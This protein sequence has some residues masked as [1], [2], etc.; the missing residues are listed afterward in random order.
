MSRVEPRP[1]Q[2]GAVEL[3]AEQRFKLAALIAKLGLEGTRKRLGCSHVTLDQLRGGG[4]VR[5]E[6]LARIAEKL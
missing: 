3:S 1:A 5:A 6:T 2:Y 4:R